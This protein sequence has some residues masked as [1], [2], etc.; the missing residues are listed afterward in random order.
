M[1]GEERKRRTLVDLATT[2]CILRREDTRS[3][4]HWAP[5]IGAEERGGVM[6]RLIGVFLAVVA[7]VT[8]FALVG[9][10]AGV[11][12]VQSATGGEI[13]VDDEMT[14]EQER[15]LSG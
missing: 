11:T 13:G 7:L 14:T 4:P 8:A 15:L 2:I 9:G 1:A 3:P 10:G 6:R 5:M 12:R